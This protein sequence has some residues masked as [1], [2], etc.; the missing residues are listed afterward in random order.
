ML[1]SA[2]A[3]LID[4]APFASVEDVSSAP[5]ADGTAGA[6]GTAVGELLLGVLAAPG[7]MARGARRAIDPLRM[8]R[9]R[10][11][12]RAPLGVDMGVESAGVAVGGAEDGATNGAAASAGSMTIAAR[13]TPE[14]NLAIRMKGSLGRVQPQF[15]GCKYV[16][17]RYSLLICR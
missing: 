4:V 9:A 10:A 2:A 15:C 8:G 11:G 3:V 13:R 1:A 12:E 14:V 5:G 17:N 7:S 6:L 16:Y